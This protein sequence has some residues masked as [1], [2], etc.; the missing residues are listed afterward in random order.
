M[1]SKYT[2]KEFKKV[3]WFIENKNKISRTRRN[4]YLTGMEE[5]YSDFIS[6]DKYGYFEHFNSAGV[7]T[8]AVKRNK[9]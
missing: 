9:R 1:K 6:Y 7:E 2:K 4:W 3:E 5:R 8:L